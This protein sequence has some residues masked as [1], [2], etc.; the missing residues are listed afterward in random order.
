[1][2]LTH[3]PLYD[4]EASKQQEH[5]QVQVDFK[6]SEEEEEDAHCFI[7]RKDQIGSL[8]LLDSFQPDKEKQKV[9]GGRGG[10]R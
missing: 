9:K 7:I 8:E 5:Q 3:P 1:M 2:L 6:T 10:G 4:P